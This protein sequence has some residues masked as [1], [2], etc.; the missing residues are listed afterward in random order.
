MLSNHEVLSLLRELDSAHIAAAKTAVRIKQ[1]E[2]AS[3]SG[4]RTTV[5]AEE[6]CEN[7]RTV[8]VEVRLSFLLLLLTKSIDWTTQAISYLSA[9]YL[10]TP[11]QT[12]ASVAKLTKAL[13]PYALTKA[14][15]LQVVNLAPTEPVE[16]YVVRPSS[17]KSF[18]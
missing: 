15:K 10:P 14:E 18:D 9:P 12:D 16:L 2:A 6:I 4:A 13:A 3:G 1:E 5:V 11:T 8:E 17:E 7:L